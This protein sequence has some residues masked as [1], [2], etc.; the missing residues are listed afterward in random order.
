ML[1]KKRGDRA[2]AAELFA[3]ILDDARL[4]PKHFQRDQR[5]W[6]ELAKRE[7]QS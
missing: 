1:Y 5:E 2:R 4:A 3:A 7:Q 6:I